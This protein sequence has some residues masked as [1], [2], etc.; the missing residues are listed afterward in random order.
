LTVSLIWFLAR[1][2]LTYHGRQVVDRDVAQVVGGRRDIVNEGREEAEQ[3]KE[4]DQAPPEFSAMF[5]WKN[6]VEKLH[7]SSKDLIR[8]SVSSAPPL[9]I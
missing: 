9:C 1:R 3:C 8:L 5:A 7:C 6:V 4:T 2:D